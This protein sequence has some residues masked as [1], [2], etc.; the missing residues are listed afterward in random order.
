MENRKQSAA[1]SSGLKA[2]TEKI[3]E[4]PAGIG[5]SKTDCTGFW[6]SFSMKDRSQVPVR[7]AAENLASTGRPSASAVGQDDQV[8]VGT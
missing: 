1:A 8:D 3:L 2:D 5:E 4:A 6:A 7:D